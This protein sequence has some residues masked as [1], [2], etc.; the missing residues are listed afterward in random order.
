MRLENCILQGNMVAAAPFIRDQPEEV[1]I[2]ARDT[3]AIPLVLYD[4]YC[5]ANYLSFGAAPSFLRDQE[6]VLFSY[7]GMLLRC[8][9]G[10]F[11]L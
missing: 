7:F 5:H 8:V 6:N 4:L 1:W 3:S 11:E 9:M 10:H 2:Q